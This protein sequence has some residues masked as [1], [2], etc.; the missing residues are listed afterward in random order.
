MHG[1]GNLTRYTIAVALAA[2]CI[3]FGIVGGL[4]QQATAAPRI[5]TTEVNVKAR[6]HDGVIQD[7]EVCDDGGGVFDVDGNWIPGTGNNTG[8]YA[9]STAG[10][11]CNTTCTGFG[12]Y[13][14][15][16][17]VDTSFD[18]ECDDG[19]NID[20][21]LCSAICLNESDPV[22]EEPPPSGGGG[23]SSGGGAG[24]DT[25]GEVPIDE[26]TELVI[27]G[28]AYPG[29]TVTIL[30]DG[31][32]E[33]VVEADSNAEFDLRLTDITPGP[34]TFGFWAQDRQGRNSI[35]F[36]TTFQVI[37][38][39]VTTL[40][41]VL[42]PPTIS[43][44]PQKMPH[45]QTVTFAG[46]A[47]PGARVFT[48][49]NDNEHQE[50]TNSAGNGEWQIAFETTPLRNE[51]F[52]TAKANFEEV[53]SGTI[54]SGWSQTVNFYVGVQDAQAPSGADLNGDGLVNLTDFS[55]LLFHWNTSNPAGDV[56][57]DGTVNLTDFSIML[58]NWT[59]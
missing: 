50:V 54:K 7:G 20:G 16:E 56:N 19:N 12:P 49:I 2:L 37:E 25:D 47:I 29:A 21:D 40:A 41:D 6:C 36:S 3:V 51:S 5:V 53:A 8:E 32:V 43:A 57:G 23:A 35:I 42:L 18:E 15:D 39:A 26:E 59:G 55:I 52:H 13:C 48:V 45:G 9:T 34:S 27:T 14:G 1:S 28:K 58:F 4:L 46:S 24:G 22:D 38:N 10:R 31:Q 17:F 30:K 33:E 44:T 11:N